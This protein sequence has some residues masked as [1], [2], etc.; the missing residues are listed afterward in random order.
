MSSTHGSIPEYWKNAIT[1]NK[2]KCIE[3]GKMKQSGAF[4]ARCSARCP[5]NNNSLSSLQCDWGWKSASKDNPLVD[6]LTLCALG[7]RARMICLS[8]EAKLLLGSSICHTF[9]YRDRITLAWPLTHT[10]VF[11]LNDGTSAPLTSFCFLTACAR[12]TAWRIQ[13]VLHLN[14][15]KRRVIFV[16]TIDSDSMVHRLTAR[17]ILDEDVIADFQ[18]HEGPC[19]VRSVGH[20]FPCLGLCPSEL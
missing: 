11:L 10:I 3:A 4:P 9:R 19:R 2:D 6:F 20:A 12:T 16:S 15:L 5:Q 7:P 13:D 14:A 1:S 18:E 8:P 17:Q